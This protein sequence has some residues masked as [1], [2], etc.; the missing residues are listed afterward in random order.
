MKNYVIHQ[1][2]LLMLV[3]A[4]IFSAPGN[5]HA[6]GATQSQ[7]E[8]ASC[9]QL[10][11]TGRAQADSPNTA[12]GSVEFTLAGERYFAKLELQFTFGPPQPGGV[13]AVSSSHV[14]TVR[15]QR[16]R[17]VG[18]FTTA[19]SGL[20]A[21]TQTPGLLDLNLTMKIVSGTGAF[22]RAAG[23]LVDKGF[24]NVADAAPASV[25]ALAGSVCNFNL[26]GESSQ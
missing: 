25:S 8:Q 19:D 14:F 24:L 26:R 17:K 22:E 12:T 2:L 7:R 3:L 15:N 21:P 18:S 9:A 20:L 6:Q 4:C 13:S 5:T 11:G 23:T 16:G 10:L 1:F